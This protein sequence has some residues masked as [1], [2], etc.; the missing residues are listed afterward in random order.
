MFI[1][2]RDFYGVTQVV[3]QQPDVTADV[4]DRL[5]ALNVETVLSIEGVVRLRPATQVNTEIDTGAVEIVAKRVDVLSVAVEPPPFPIAKGPASN[6]ELRLRY[7]FLYLRRA[8]MRNMLVQR[9]R[10]CQLIRESFGK[11]GFVEIHTPILSN[12]TPEGARDFIVPSR[13]HPGKFFALPQAPQQWKQLAVASG[14]D[15]YF[16]IAPCFRDEPPRADRSPGEFYQLDIE[17]AF[18]EQEDVLREVES[19]IIE[20]GRQYT[21]KK[22]I[23]P[24]QRIRYE[25]AL[26]RYGSDKPDTRFGLE[27]RTLTEYFANSSVQFLREAVARGEAVRGFAIPEAGQRFSRRDIDGLQNIAKESQVN[28]L[29]WLAWTSD[30]VRGSLANAMGQDEIEHLRT[31]FDASDGTLVLLCAGQR[32][33]I[34]TALNAVRLEVGERLGL[35]DP[36]ILQFMWVLDFPMYEQDEETGQIVF[37]HNPFSM[38]HGGLEALNTLHPLEIYGQQYDLACNGVEISSGAIRNNIPEVLYRAFE[39]AGYPASEVDEKF[40]HMIK[41]FQFG[42]PPH[43]GIAPGFER[44]MMIFLGEESIRDV[45]PYPKNQR[46]QDLMVN[47]PSVINDA[48]LRELG[49]RVVEPE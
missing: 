14:V 15:R 5:D 23:E 35:R 49:I 7:R 28:G 37:S 43:G 16:Q 10:L 3:V 46:C 18:V 48:Q 45:I 2:L 1:D 27:L 22:I 38:P 41:A 17:M 39:I 9:N 31:V 21:T 40:G 20:I 36:N 24:F 34:D 6:E 30:G 47:A 25:D 32:R 44:L 33:R 4:I 8:R 26:E 12:S 11:R 29:A 19:L 42:C 13:L